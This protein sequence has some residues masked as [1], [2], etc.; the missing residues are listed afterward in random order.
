MHYIDNVV[1]FRKKSY[2]ASRILYFITDVLSRRRQ[3]FF[4]KIAT[5]YQYFMGTNLSMLPTPI[6]ENTDADR[7]HWWQ[8]LNNS[9]YYTIIERFIRTHPDVSTLILIWLYLMLNFSF[10]NKTRNANNIWLKKS[11]LWYAEKWH[12]E[13]MF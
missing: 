2:E 11:W 7:K 8:S 13:S 9:F 5:S 6:Q 10:L 1:R 3:N 12:Y 4:L